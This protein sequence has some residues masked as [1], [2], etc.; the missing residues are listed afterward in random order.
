M[1]ESVKA[2]PG[3]VSLTPRCPYCGAD[4]APIVPAFTRFGQGQ[5]T[6]W[7][8]GNPECR[9]VHSVQLTGVEQSRTQEPLII[10]PQ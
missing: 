8:C 10:R 1:S 6:V 3:N 5:I 2:G 9:G 7:L 4:P